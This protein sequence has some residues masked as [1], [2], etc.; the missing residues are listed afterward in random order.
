MKKIL[1]ILF[2]AAALLCAA[3]CGNPESAGVISP[4]PEPPSASDAAPP[5]TPPENKDSTKT[6][7]ETKN[8]VTIDN[9]SFTPQELT[10][11][12]NTTVTWVNHDDIPHTVKDTQKRFKSSTLDTDEKYSFT[13]TE[14]GTYDY[15]C[16]I[17]PKMTG[18]IIVK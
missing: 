2:S 16:T 12:V 13:F 10:V 9:F 1:H 14:P 17:H 11:P 8:T 18:K 15:F 5:S 3:S 4:R 6:K 7:D